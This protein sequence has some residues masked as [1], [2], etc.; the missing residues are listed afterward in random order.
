MNKSKLLDWKNDRLSS[1]LFVIAISLIIYMPLHV[2]IAQ[3][4][5]LLTGGLE[6]WKAAKDVFVVLLVPLMIYLSYRR[7]LF[8]NKTF[9]WLIILGGIYALLHALFVAFDNNDDTYSAIVASVYNTRIFGYLLLGYLVGTAKNGKTYLK[10]LLTGAVLIAFVVALFGVL[11]YFLPSDLLTNVGYSLE[12]GVKPL[13]FIDDRPE[14]PRVM[15]TLKDPNSLGAYLILPILAVGFALFSKGANKKLFVRPFRKG[16]LAVFLGIMVSALILTFSRG[17]LLGL[18]LSIIT[19][20]CI[21]TGERVTSYLKKYYIFLIAFIF[22]VS[23]FIFQIRNS[24][25][26]QDYIFH[27]AVST[28]QEDPNEKRVTLLQDSIYEVIDQPT[29]YGPGTAGL[30]SI[31]NPQGGVLTEN[32]YVQI[33][34]EVGWLGIILFV[35]ILSIITY[36]LSKICRKSPASAMLLS[37]LVAYLFYSLLI[38][39][40]SNEAV[41][42]QWWLLTG[43][44]LGIT[45]NPK[46]AK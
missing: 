25:I 5:S 24:A 21:V 7:S 3:S 42:L 11:Q 41:A 39:L 1:L 34:Y 13:F 36:Q 33:A 19:L 28:N 46:G 14:L 31:N 20:L 44:M 15:S 2:F 12:R 4:A 45:L 29:G 8:A 32:Y 17:A 30:V 16:T 26:V 35:A 22:L 37:A 38:H 18:I 43:V 9:R 6:V 23:F 10:Y 27:A 40:W